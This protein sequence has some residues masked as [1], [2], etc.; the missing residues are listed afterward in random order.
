MQNKKNLEKTK[1]TREKKTHFPEVLGRRGVSQESQNIGFIVFFV[2]FRSFLHF[3]MG[4][5]PKESQNID[6][7]AVCVFDFIVKY[8]FAHMF[9]TSIC[10]V[11]LICV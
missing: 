7:F 6:L 9:Q 5:L 11:C 1:K 4:A 3:S 10:T 2:F 8:T